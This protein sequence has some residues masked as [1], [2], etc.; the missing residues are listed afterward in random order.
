[1]SNALTPVAPGKPGLKRRWLFVIL[2]LTFLFV[3]M[4]FLF[5]QAT[6]FGKP[7][8]DA[9]LEKSLADRGHP[10]EIQHALSQLADRILAR[11]AS[12]RDSARRF[13]PQ[14]IQIAQNGQDELR[15]T[16]AWVMGQDNS[17]PDFH[18]EL[19]RLLQDPNPMVRRNAALALVRFGDA[20]G[21]A[22]IRSMLQPDTITAPSSGTALD[23]RLKSGD[24]INPGTLLGRMEHGDRATEELRSQIP[25]A[26]GGWLVP[27]KTAVAA[28]QP[29]LLVNPSAD[30]LWESL[31]AL[32]L[33]GEARDLPAVEE[34]AR[35]SRDVPANVRQQAELTA[36]AIRSRQKEKRGGVHSASPVT[37]PF[38]TLLRYFL[39]T[40]LPFPST[41]ALAS[42]C[43]KMLSTWPLVVSKPVVSAFCLRSSHLPEALATTVFPFSMV[44]LSLSITSLYVP[45]FTMVSPNFTGASIVSVAFLGLA[46]E[47]AGLSAFAM[48]GKVSASAARAR[49]NRNATFLIV[50]FSFFGDRSPEFLA[51]RAAAETR[52][53]CSHGCALKC[54]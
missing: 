12:T 48:T 43:R 1:M 8:D 24:A 35:G 16:A 46:S 5:W 32:Y 33:I 50:S 6:W 27:D 25:G 44:A 54:R 3:L 34:L 22:E 17:V 36:T 7:L 37:G 18:Q 19:L 45:G 53:K 20:S 15:L 28:G 51:G 9:N 40:W 26:I 21:R 30:E 11:D 47:L 10:R 41:N 29:V 52:C 2:A 14:V 42:P 23:E 4:P 38:T 49:P 13:Y 39:L 31:R